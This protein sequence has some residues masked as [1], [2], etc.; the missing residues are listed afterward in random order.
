MR[1]PVYKRIFLNFVLVIA[2]FGIMG[3]IL[4]ASLISRNTLTEAQR[5]VRLDLRSAWSI[6]QGEIDS[7]R[8]FVV[9]LAGGSRVANAY[10]EPESPACRATM[11]AVRRKCGFDFLS[12]TN[13]EGRVI[14][15]TLEPYHTGDYLSNDPLVSQALQGKTVS[16]FVI[17]GPQRLHAE[18]GDLEERA[19]IVFE[20]TAKAKP[21]AKASESSGMALMTATPVRDEKGNISG[22]LYAGILLNRNHSL[23]DRIRSIIFEDKIYDGRDLGTV[24]IFQW[25]ARIATNVMTASGNRAI[26]TRVSGDVY[27]KVLENNL[28]WYD[29]AF[30]VND[31]YLSAYDPIHDSRGKVIGILYVGVL[32]KKYDDI[33]RSLW[34]LYGAVSIGVV[35]IVLVLGLIFSRRLTG[36]LS[37]LADAAG[38]ISNGDLE[39]KVPEPS[40]DDEI[41]D[42]TRSFNAMAES[43]R[44]REERLKLANTELESTNVS[45]QQI[46]G[47]YLDMLGFVS[48]ELKNTLGVI[49]TSARALDT[50]IVGVLTKSQGA[51]VGNISKSIDRAVRMTRNYLDL[52]RI[53]K[54]EL[55]V[56]AKEIDIAGDVVNPVIDELGQAMAD[57][58]M[59]IENQLPESLL[60]TGDPDLLQIVY[61]NLLH[62]ALKYGRENGKIKIG[63]KQEETRYQFEVWNEGRGLSPDEIALLFQRFVRLGDDVKGYRSTGLGLFITKEIIEKHGGTIRA[64]SQPGDWINF[65]FTLPR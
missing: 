60:Y 51:L 21:R 8:L 14:V 63:F 41:L 52:A 37:R 16:G 61:K 6:I 57:N 64:E 15:R 7:L 47:N 39:L 25:D 55:I 38:R 30:V 34:N 29:R 40:A 28:N 46:N 4:S 3:A 45:L 49:Y 33:K 13:S 22:V 32:A 12:L 65:I 48:H 23:A 35:I 17:L 59:T 56:Q 36:S 50:G 44:D 11:E 2:L 54:G 53:E 1:I 42:L 24:T 5:R 26:G 58:G 10:R 31:W 62:N 20:P 9:V 18:G 19:F 43:L 27:D